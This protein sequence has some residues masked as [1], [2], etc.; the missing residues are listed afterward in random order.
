MSELEKGIVDEQ[1]STASETVPILSQTRQNRILRGQLVWTLKFC[2][3]PRP[4][5]RLRV[6]VLDMSLYFLF[7]PHEIVCNAASASKDCD[8]PRPWP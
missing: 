2:R 1:D 5:P 8:C 6:F 7:E 3:R 4:C